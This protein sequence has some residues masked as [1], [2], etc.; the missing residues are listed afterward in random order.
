MKKIVTVALLSA[1]LSVSYGQSALKPKI[2]TA[3]EAIEG[4]TQNWETVK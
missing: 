4:K 3:A 2:S 1:T